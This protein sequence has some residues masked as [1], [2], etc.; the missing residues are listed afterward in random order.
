MRIIIPAQF[1]P[2]RADAD[3]FRVMVEAI[4]WFTRL[5]KPHRSDR[6]VIRVRSWE[7]CPFLDASGRMSM[8]SE[9]SDWQEQ[10]AER[11]IDQD[12][13]L[14][15]WCQIGGAGIYQAGER[16]GSD[17]ERDVDYPPNAAEGAA[18][19]VAAAIG[20]FVRLGQEIPRNA[21]RQ[22]VWY[23]RGHFP[24]AYE[25]G[26]ESPAYDV[27]GIPREQARLVVF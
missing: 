12:E 9:H 16:I 14:K 15:Y 25:D 26:V 22:W 1:D 2:R 20:C 7:E 19:W 4:P 3:S 18:A 27:A 13:F 11:G 21:L 17:S 24:A 8:T 10:I 5:G 6:A 23:A